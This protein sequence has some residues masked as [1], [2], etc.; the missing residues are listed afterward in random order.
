MKLPKAIAAGLKMTFV[1]EGKAGV[2]ATEPSPARL[3]HDPQLR[4]QVSEEAPAEDPFEIAGRE[5]AAG[6]YHPGAWA[7]AVVAVNGDVLQVQAKYVRIR[8]EA[9]Q[10]QAAK[11]Q[12]IYAAALAEAAERER[13]ERDARYAKALKIQVYAKLLSVTAA[14]AACM[15]RFGIR[16]DGDRFHYREHRYERL[17][18]AVAYARLEAGDGSG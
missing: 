11:R 13:L 12:T 17:D 10:A 8:V 2:A 18:D 14:E 6:D 3:R 4:V 9:L 16:K 15:L 7:R 1:F 5:L